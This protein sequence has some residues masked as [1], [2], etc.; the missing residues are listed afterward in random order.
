MKESDT[1]AVNAN[2]EQRQ[3]VVLLSITG[4]YMKE[5]NILAVNANFKQRQGVV[6]LSITGEYMKGSDTLADNVVNISLR[7]DI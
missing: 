7:R 4:E 1:L 6:L 5:S 3:E 2:I